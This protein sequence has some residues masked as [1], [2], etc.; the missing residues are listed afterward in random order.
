MSCT[1]SCP[2]GF[3]CGANH[4]CLVNGSS[5]LGQVTLRIGD[6]EDLDLSLVEPDGGA[7]EMYWEYPNGAPP[8]PGVACGML[9]SLRL[10]SSDDCKVIQANMENAKYPRAPNAPVGCMRCG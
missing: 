10:Q 9:G 7:C 2:V 5:G 3:T 1:S 8:A 4:E 6:A